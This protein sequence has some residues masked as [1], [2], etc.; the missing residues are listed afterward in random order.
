MKRAAIICLLTVFAVAN[1][2]SGALA[3]DQAKSTAWKIGTLAPK[4]VGWAVQV[5]EVLIPEVRKASGDTIQ[6]KFYWGGI[7]GD[8]EHIIE[9][10]GKGVLNGG[11]L[12]GQGTNLACPQFTVLSLPFMFND[13]DEVDYI[14]EKMIS[15]FDQYMRKNGFYMIAWVDQDFDQIYSITKP[16]VKAADFNRTPCISWFGPV[17]EH[18]FLALSAEPIITDVP[19][20][21]KRVKKGGVDGN[22]GPAIWVVGTQLYSK[23]RYI[24]PI[25]IRYSPVAFIVSLKSWNSIDAEHRKS[26]LSIRDEMTKKV[27]RKVRE[28]NKQC[29]DAMA[30]YGVEIIPSPPEELNKL[31]QLTKPVWNEL[32]G[33]EYPAPVLTE[34]LGRLR[35]YRKTK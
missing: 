17:E 19:D 20:V 4:G 21:A 35:E 16:L 15:S 11:G 30:Q 14:R 10:I 23:F 32:A 1:L 2:L 33:T 26:I 31:K 18:T 28:S 25:N 24:N 9:K 6:I 13:Y 12:S 5:D 29:L 8:D 3:A 7:M 34:L 22:I 27:V